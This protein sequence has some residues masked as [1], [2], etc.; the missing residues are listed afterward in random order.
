MPSM[1][2]RR[3]RAISQ[4]INLFFEH[5]DSI[6]AANQLCRE[7]DSVTSTFDN[8]QR[9]SRIALFMNRSMMSAYILARRASLVPVFLLVALYVF[10]CNLGF[11]APQL[12]PHFSVISL[13][14]LG[15]LALGVVFLALSYLSIRGLTISDHEAA[16]LQWFNGIQIIQ[17]DLI[18]IL[19]SEL[20]A[21]TSIA[22]HHAFEVLQA[23]QLSVERAAR[24]YRVSLVVRAEGL[25]PLLA[26]EAQNSAHL[27]ETALVIEEPEPAVA[28]AGRTDSAELVANRTQ[29]QATTHATILIALAEAG[30]EAETA[31]E[32]E[33]DVAPAPRSLSESL[34]TDTRAHSIA[35]PHTLSDHGETGSSLPDTEPTSGGAEEITESRGPASP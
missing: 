22:T 16:N 21:L 33:A 9:S 14:G 13:V 6:E 31:A 4:S 20:A 27:L 28:D 10:M 23:R 11:R 30:A 32:A 15:P 35:P 3:V 2:E 5:R 25:P 24:L 12:A 7:I 8:D 18:P 17:N 19:Q 1:L 29:G 34:G 26:R